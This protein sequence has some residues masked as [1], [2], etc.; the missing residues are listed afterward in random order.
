MGFMLIGLLIGKRLLLYSV[1]RSSVL[2]SEPGEI[3]PRLIVFISCAFQVAVLLVVRTIFAKTLEG[4]M[5][6]SLG[7]WLYALL[8]GVVNGL[9]IGICF[10]APMFAA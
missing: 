3:S 10:Q 2:G 9:L 6:A 4:L 5:P 7:F 8:F 1:K